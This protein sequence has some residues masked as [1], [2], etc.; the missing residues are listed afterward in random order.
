MIENP[1]AAANTG[2]DSISDLVQMRLRKN[3]VLSSVF[4]D[5]SGFATPGDKS[6]S[7]P[8]W[9]NEFNVQKLSGAQKGDDQEALFDLDKLELNQERHIQWAIKKFDQARAKVRILDQAIAEATQQHAIDFDQDMYDKIVADML[10]AN[11]L[12]GT[13]DQAKVVDMITTLNKLRVPRDGRT[14]IFG[15]D[16]YGTLL[17]IDGF[18]D[19][20]KSNLDIVRNGQIGTLYGI[21]VVES[22]VVGAGVSLLVHRMALGYAF[23][24]QPEL[25]DEKA[26]EFGTG[27]RRFVMDMLTGEKVL[28][29][30]RLIVSVGL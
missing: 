21:P 17:K 28:Q 2:Q 26:I 24:A 5:L 4:E 20:S 16:A 12:A 29:G 9:S 30:G 3:S 13:L 1:T 15:N 7:F 23:G 11:K 22:D 18:V 14:F 10:A 19:A 8:R 27:S 25:E 6:V